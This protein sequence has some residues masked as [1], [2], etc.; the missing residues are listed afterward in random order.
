MDMDKDMDVTK[1]TTILF[2]PDLYAQLAA[3]AEQRHSSVGQLVRDACRAQY[4]ISSQSQRLA[5]VQELAAMNLP[6]G[7]VEEMERESVPEVE[8]I[9]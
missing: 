4:A 6:V 9:W 3:I 7:S 1:K 8:E 2:P 5:L